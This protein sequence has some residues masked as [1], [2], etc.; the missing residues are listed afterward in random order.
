MKTLRNARSVRRKSGF[1]L[2][3]LLATVT[4][5]CIFAGML[6]PASVSNARE[7]AGIV[8]CL[9]NLKQHGAAHS[10]LFQ[11]RGVRAEPW[12]RLWIQQLQTLDAALKDAFCP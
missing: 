10:T 3:D 6:L 5:L 7:K 11:D 4:L 2:S 1:S 8:L 12:P 9:N